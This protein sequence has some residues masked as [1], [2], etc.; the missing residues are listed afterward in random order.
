MTSN[1]DTVA[2]GSIRHRKRDIEGNNIGRANSNPIIDTRA[3]EVEFEDWSMSTYSEMSLQKV[4]MLSVMRRY[5]NN[6]SLDK[7]WITRHMGMPY[8]W[9]IKM[10]LYVSEVRNEKQQKVGTCVSNESMGQQHGRGYPISKN[11]TPFRLHINNLH[12]VSTMSMSSIG[13]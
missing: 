5:S 9:R 11:P 8:R 13:G 4:F 7:N 12:R 10:W 6:S 2:Q 1:G 3:Y